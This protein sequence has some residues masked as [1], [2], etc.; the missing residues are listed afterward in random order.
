MNYVYSNLCVCACHLLCAAVEGLRRLQD[1][2]SALELSRLP[3]ADVAQLLLKRLQLHHIL[4]LAG[5][6]QGSDLLVQ[7]HVDSKPL[8]RAHIE[9]SRFT[10]CDARR[11]ADSSDCFQSCDHMQASVLGL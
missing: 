4:L 5:A 2:L 3:V 7:L 9:R 10:L 8:L 6:E 11:H 1:V